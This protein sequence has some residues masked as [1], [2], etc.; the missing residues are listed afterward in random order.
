ML[1]MLAICLL[2][3][4]TI[5]ISSLNL[6]KKVLQRKCFDPNVKLLYLF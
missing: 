4:M 5:Y 3:M 6:P 2:W 1:W